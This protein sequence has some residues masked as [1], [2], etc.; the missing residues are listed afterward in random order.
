MRK[1]I[2]SVDLLGEEYADLQLADRDDAYGLCT[3][4]LGCGVAGEHP[5]LAVDA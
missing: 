2:Y 3:G 4:F 5:H 1:L